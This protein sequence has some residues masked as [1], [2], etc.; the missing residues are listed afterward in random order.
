MFAHFDNIH[1]RD[2]QTDRCRMTAS[3][4]LTHSFAQQKIKCIQKF[5]NICSLTL[6]ILILPN[7]AGE[8]SDVT[9]KLTNRNPVNSIFQIYSKEVISILCYLT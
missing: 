7:V 8:S 4:V 5:R 1:K 3:A 9:F 2:R 6:S